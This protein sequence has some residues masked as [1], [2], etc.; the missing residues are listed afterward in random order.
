MVLS[1]EHS[2][3][4]AE[5]EALK[6]EEDMEKILKYARGK[7]TQL[8]QNKLDAL[9]KMWLSYRKYECEFETANYVGALSYATVLEN[10][11]VRMTYARIRELQNYECV[12]GTALICGN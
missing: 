12:K 4:A 2:A 6:A 9:Q 10:C 1:A 8:W 11:Y 7:T 5:K 3:E